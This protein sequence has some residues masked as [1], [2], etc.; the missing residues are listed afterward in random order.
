MEEDLYIKFERKTDEE[1]KTIIDKN[2]KFILDLMKIS[3]IANLVDETTVAEEI[4][5]KRNG[6]K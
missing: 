4:L 2:S 6:A 3:N 5:N 1:L